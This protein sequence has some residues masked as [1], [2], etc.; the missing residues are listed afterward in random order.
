MSGS[1]EGRGGGVVLSSLHVGVRAPG[2]DWPVHGPSVAP[3]PVCPLS[4]LCH[5]GSWSWGVCLYA[6]QRPFWSPASV[7]TRN[8]V[9]GGSSQYLEREPRKVTLRLTLC[10]IFSLIPDYFWMFPELS[11]SIWAFA[12][13]KPHFPYQGGAGPGQ[14]LILEGSCCPLRHVSP[15]PWACWANSAV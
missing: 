14:P 8:G 7:H 4:C 12:E 10:F 5:V 6:C 1:S 15:P 2:R 11:S 13:Q 9:M 3:E